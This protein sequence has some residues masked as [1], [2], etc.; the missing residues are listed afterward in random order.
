MSEYT[1]TSFSLSASKRKAEKQESM[2]KIE[3]FN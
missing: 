3:Y 1:D 2:K